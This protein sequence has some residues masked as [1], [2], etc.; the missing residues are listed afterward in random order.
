[1]IYASIIPIRY[2]PLSWT[3]TW[4]RFTQ[5]PWLT[6]GLEKRA[7]WVANGLVLIPFGFFMSGSILWKRSNIL[8]SLSFFVLFAILHGAFVCAI[9]FFQIWFPPRVLSQNDMLAGYL[10]GLAG[11]TFWHAVGQRVVE[12]VFKFIRSEPGLPRITILAKCCA[13]GLLLYSLMPLDVML[14]LSE[15][16]QKFWQDRMTFIPFSDWQGVKEAVLSIL[17]RISR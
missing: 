10:G 9:E 3:D 17:L 2:T 13:I 5:I 6:L 4:F 8:L 15:W 7:D 14:S 12:E 11:V 1:V 16:K